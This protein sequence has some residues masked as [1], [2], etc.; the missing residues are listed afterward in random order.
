VSEIVCLG[1]KTPFKF[2]SIVGGSYDSGGGL[3]LGLKEV[4]GG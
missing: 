3:L 4:G 1:G 2:V